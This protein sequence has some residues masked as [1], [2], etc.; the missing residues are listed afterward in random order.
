MTTPSDAP[1]DPCAGS[2]PCRQAVAELYTYVDGELDDTT[3]ATIAQHLDDCAPCLEH[4]EFHDD[5][6]RVIA[7]RCRESVPDELRSR[8]FD[9]I[10]TDAG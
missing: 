8:I 6:K 7:Q 5:L 4:F 9:A 3:R 1:I 2:D 10:A